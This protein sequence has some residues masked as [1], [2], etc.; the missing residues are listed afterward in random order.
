MSR[1]VVVLTTV[2]TPGQ[3]RSLSRAL[4][5]SRLAA[6]VSVLPVRSR[7]WWEG[8]LASGRESLLVVKT[9]RALLPRLREAVLRLHPYEVPEFLA[10][11]VLAGHKPYLSWIDA[12]TTPPETPKRGRRSG[13]RR[14]RSPR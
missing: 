1:H 2:G 4:L 7:Y 6:C 14:L 9:R 5:S 11:G 8:R 12:E 13:P 3:A 10:L